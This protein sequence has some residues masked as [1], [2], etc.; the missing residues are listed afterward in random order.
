MF[1][2]DHQA[3]KN[4]VEKI[5]NLD[6]EV[7]LAGHGKILTKNASKLITDYYNTLY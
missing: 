1:I 7:M 3:L 6:S 5:S 2:M 4:S